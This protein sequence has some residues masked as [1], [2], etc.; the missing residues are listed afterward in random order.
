[1]AVLERQARVLGVRAVAPLAG[2]ELRA[3]GGKA[4]VDAAE[5]DCVWVIAAADCAV[6]PDELAVLEGGGIGAGGGD[7]A[8]GAG[9]DDERLGKGVLAVAVVDIAHV[10]DHIGDYDADHDAA[11]AGLR[12]RDCLDGGQFICRGEDKG[13]VGF[14]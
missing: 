13:A 12:G 6:D 1:M 8:D 10:G 7:A 3:A 9:A 14:G 4:L 5:H 11:R 2:H